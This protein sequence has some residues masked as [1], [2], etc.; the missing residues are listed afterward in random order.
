MLNMYKYFFTFSLLMISCCIYAFQE[1]STTS[2]GS[3]TIL[4]PVDFGDAYIDRY[5]ADPDFLYIEESLEESWI[6]RL[7]KKFF[8]LVDRFF[9]WLIGDREFGKV[10]QFLMQSLPYLA[11]FI[12]LIILVW[13]V[14]KYD[15]EGSDRKIE[16][17]AVAE[18]ENLEVL[19]Q[20][21]I[22]SLIGSAIAVGD[23]RLAVRYSYLSVLKSMMDK[24][25]I[26]WGIQ[27]TNHD[28][29]KELPSGSLKASFAAVTRIYDYIWYGGFDVD[30]EDFERV[31]A[32]FGELKKEL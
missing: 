22:N 10:A 25:L 32:V 13:A 6:D 26:D 3:E 20:E 21:D 29:M 27:K 1:E 9:Y 23:Y 4:A 7:Q 16:G 5:S 12:L 14:M 18:S 15:D 31:N 2:T 28:Y 24:S 19:A 8:Q 30:K 17:F 11:V